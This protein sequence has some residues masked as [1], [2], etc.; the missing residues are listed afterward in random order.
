MATVAD[1]GTYC[2]AHVVNLDQLT[3]DLK[4]AGTTPAFAFITPGLCHDGHDA[5]CANGKPGG[6][7]SIDRFLKTWVRRIT[8][9][10]AF[11]KNGMLVITFDESGDE[12]TAC[13]GE[14]GLPGGP[15]PGLTGPG[16]G[17]VGAVVLSPFIRPGTRSTVDYNHYSLLR[18][19][20]RNFGLKPLGYAAL[21]D[22]RVFGSDVFDR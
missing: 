3:L 19:V 22:M 6:L 10:P 13:C 9:S 4:H 18:T 2:S 17:R 14:Q 11:R 7:I 8:S 12:A 20:E 21:P 5:P 1:A 15:K 16:G